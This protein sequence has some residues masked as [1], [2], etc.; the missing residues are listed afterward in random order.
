M[1]DAKTEPDGRQALMRMVLTALAIVFSA[2]VGVLAVFQFTDAERERELKRWQQ[3]LGIVADSRLADVESWIESQ[4]AVMRDLAENG[5]L[6]LYLSVLAEADPGADTAEATYLRNLLTVVAQREKFVPG[7]APAAV[8]A[9]VGSVGVAGIA[10][11]NGEG[12][13]IVASPS[14][15]LIEGP[16]ATFIAGADRGKSAVSSIFAGPSGAPVIAFLAPILDVQADVATD[17]P[18]GRVLGVKPA[19]PELYAR[20][21]QPGSV[22]VTAEALLVQ[23][24]GVTVA[25]LSPQADGTA[26]LARRLAEDTPEL[27][28]SFALKSPGGFARK[29]DYDDTEVLVTSRAVSDVPWVL[30][31]KVDVAE[32]LAESESRIQQIGIAFLLI[33]GLV[34]IGMAALWYYGASRRA[35]EAARRF[36]KLAAEFQ[37]QRDF[38]HLVTDSQPNS[39]IIYDPDG[40][41]RWFNRVAVEQSGLDRQSLRGKHVSSI[42]GPV[43][44]R[45]IAG[46][47]ADCLEAAKPASHIHTMQE[48]S[49]EERVYSS[50]L[51]PMPVTRDERQGV[52]VVS[53]DITEAVLERTRRERI[54]RQLVNTLVGVVDRR[55]PYS[56]NHSVRVGMVARAIAGEMNLDSADGEV[57]EIAGNLMNLGKIAVPESVLTKTEA[58]TEPEI[59]MVRDSVLASADLV[60]DIEFDGPVAE[61]I[62]QLQEHF[63]G[64]GMPDGLKGEDI[65]PTARIVAVANTFVAM[66]S[67]RSYRQG[68]DFDRAMAIL[69]KES[70]AAFDRR[71]VTALI[72]YIENRDGRTEWASFG[73]PAITEEQ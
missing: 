67:A 53:Q 40:H 19:S 50:D 3:R 27:A 43:V 7:I 23:R 68:M 17:A 12:R 2:G 26:P 1:Q 34:L 58:L 42:V 49:G 71:A 63:D 52:L 60:A 41:Y 45:Q 64:T 56:A 13:T 55:D 48:E 39:I 70:G 16:L 46:W 9:N 28:A 29:R 25:Y 69:Q 36:E 37:N 33:I 11:L 10:L 62:R 44:G 30:M 72:H 6:Q 31:Y 24:D 4:M 22:D 65:L 20:L 54:M 57:V 38:M 47:V 18:I 21:K 51:I 5:S 15:P 59:R 66:V 14:M 73:N 32:A 61:T 35:T 8:S